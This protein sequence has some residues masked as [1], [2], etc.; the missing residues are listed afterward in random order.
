MYKSIGC[1]CSV[2]S[3]L[4]VPSPGPPSPAYGNAVLMD[5]N[6]IRPQDRV[7]FAMQMAA[8]DVC[9]SCGGLKAQAAHKCWACWCQ[10][11]PRTYKKRPLS[12]EQIE[13]LHALM[14]KL[15][16]LKSR[17]LRKAQKALFWGAVS[18]G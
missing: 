13:S 18:H 8:R 9:P 7:I 4:S 17:R 12:V 5:G 11:R 2:S 14:A 15:P 3:Q 1:M 16:S 10:T 6:S